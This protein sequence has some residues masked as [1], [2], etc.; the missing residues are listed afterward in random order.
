[1][2]SSKATGCYSLLP[3]TQLHSAWVP[4]ALADWLVYSLLISRSPVR[5]RKRDGFEDFSLGGSPSGWKVGQSVGP[6]HVAG[7]G[8]GYIH[9][10]TAPPLLVGRHTHTHTHRS[11]RHERTRVGHHSRLAPT[12]H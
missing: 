1:M 10:P 6:A 4:G 11:P 12:T 8:D 9:V 7:G 5:I 3:G 2:T